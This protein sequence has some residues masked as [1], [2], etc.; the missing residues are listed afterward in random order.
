MSADDM[1]NFPWSTPGPP[2]IWQVRQVL[3]VTI[4]YT[5]LNLVLGGPQLGSVGCR[6]QSTLQKAS[7]GLTV[8]ESTQTCAVGVVVQLTLTAHH[9]RAGLSAQE[10]TQTCA[11][12]VVAQWTAH[13]AGL[14]VQES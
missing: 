1:S 10:S 8:Q 11:V 12:G 4:A 6:L 13:K 7:A 3:A 14:A 2:G 9:A 5:S